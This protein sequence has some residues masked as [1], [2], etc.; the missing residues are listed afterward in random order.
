MGRM[1]FEDVLPADARARWDA[2]ATFWDERMGQ[3]N[4][5]HLQLV[6]PA[7]LELLR[8]QPREKMLELA[9]GN[10]QFA[11]KLASLGVQV[12]ATDFSPAMIERARARAKP[13]DAQVEYR[14]VDATDENAL[15]SLGENVF[16]AIVCNMAI[17]DMSAI[18]PM[19]RVAPQ[20]L[21]PR[22][23][24]VL[25]TMHPCFNSNNPMFAAEFREEN[26]VA[27]E[28]FVL[29]LDRYLSSH[30]YQGLAMSEQPIA[31]FYFHRPL[32][33]L[34]GEAFRAGLVLDGLLEPR[35]PDALTSARWASWFNYHEFP[36]VLVARLR[37]SNQ[38][39]S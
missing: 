20:L 13:F 26:G 22:G 21:K 18:A 38:D 37:A 32:H 5:F 33:E 31:H 34:L 28:T 39:R 6:E 8:A 27:A 10:G 25:A 3:G 9:C 24:F 16:D 17:M 1:K 30:A 7:V 23:R 14:V 4:A 12:T 36:P 29:K 19:F 35:I 2:N 15:R 11:R